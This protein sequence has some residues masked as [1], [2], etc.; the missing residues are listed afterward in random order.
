M[1]DK[2]F[3]KIFVVSEMHKS[4]V[5]VQL[6]GPHTVWYQSSVETDTRPRLLYNRKELCGEKAQKL[7]SLI[8]LY[9]SSN[10]GKTK[11]SK[12]FPLKNFGTFFPLYPQ[13]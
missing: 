6:T 3:L 9:R 13:I 5:P 7:A 1:R 4:C 2:W 12:F 8:Y 11:C 10:A